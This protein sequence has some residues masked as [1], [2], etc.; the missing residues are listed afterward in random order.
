MTRQVLACYAARMGWFARRWWEEFNWLI[1]R[2]PTLRAQ[3]DFW[4]CRGD[5]DYRRA[6]W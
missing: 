3:F 6:T 4:A 5:Y 2:T 1:D